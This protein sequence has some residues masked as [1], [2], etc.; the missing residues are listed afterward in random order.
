MPWDEPL[1]PHPIPTSSTTAGVAAAEGESGGD[2][3]GGRV[4][5]DDAPAHGGCQPEED[6]SEDRVGG[7]QEEGDKKEGGTRLAALYACLTYPL[8]AA[9]TNGPT[10]GANLIAMFAICGALLVFS[11]GRLVTRDSRGWWK[12]AV[13]KLDEERIDGDA[14]G[15]DGAGARELENGPPLDGAGE[16]VHAPAG[17]DL[18]AWDTREE[19]QRGRRGRSRERNVGVVKR[20]NSSS[21]RRNAPLSDHGGTGGTGHG[22]PVGD[23]TEDSFLIPLGDSSRVPDNSFGNSGGERSVE[24]SCLG[25]AR[26]GRVRGVLRSLR[27]VTV[28]RGLLDWRQLGFGVAGFA[29]G[30]TCFALEGAPATVKSYHLWHGAWHVLAMGSTVPLLRARRWG[31]VETLGGDDSS[32]RRSGAPARLGLRARLHVCVR[33]C[34][35]P[36]ENRTYEMVPDRQLRDL[37]RRSER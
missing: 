34:R 32:G 25:P 18:D 29:L 9:V 4:L 31:G 14:G 5:G 15:I 1:V 7:G 33:R 20:R 35:V 19:G 27:R 37:R 28:D 21:P 2:E 36:N 30:L 13:A 17:R 16:A 22:S 6:E 23:L 12:E 8:L 10:A 3:G 24:P 26:V 11:W